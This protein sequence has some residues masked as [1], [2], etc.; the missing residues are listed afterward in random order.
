M[1]PDEQ[2]VQYAEFLAMARDEGL[3]GFDTQVAQAPH[4]G[5]GHVAIV[6]AV[7]RTVQGGFSAVGEASPRSAPPEWHPF[8]VTLA[9]LR[10]KARALR[11]LTGLDHAVVEE[12]EAPY[13]ERANPAPSR[14]AQ[15]PAARP[16]QAAP[17]AQAAR[18]QPASAALGTGPRPVQESAGDLGQMADGRPAQGQVKR[19]GVVTEDVDDED[20]EGQEEHK[21]RPDLPRGRDRVDSPD[22]GTPP[23]YAAGEPAAPDADERGAD[24]EPI[25]RDMESKLIKLAMSIAALESGEITES[26]ARHKLDDFFTRA[27]KHP[28]ARATRIEGQRVVQRLSGDLS[29][30]RAQGADER[31]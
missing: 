1:D 25:N 20:Q 19:M 8:L 12:L 21:E 11:D 9:E 28:L 15:P 27:F 4:D 5:N 16:T 7:A 24:F 22:A 2:A 3:V 14:T 6:I 10:A 29:K 13:L 26:E 23:N 30:L 31:E 18:P 17:H